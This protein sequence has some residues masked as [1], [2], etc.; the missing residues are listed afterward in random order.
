[1]AEPAGTVLTSGV[2]DT[3]RVTGA[4]IGVGMADVMDTEEEVGVAVETLCVEVAT[5]TVDVGEATI[6]DDGAVSNKLLLKIN[7]GGGSITI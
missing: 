7:G 6:D 3:D 5:G 4:G 1:M 2:T